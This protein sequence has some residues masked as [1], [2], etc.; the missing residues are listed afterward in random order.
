[1]KWCLWVFV[2]GQAF[3]SAVAIVGGLMGS[4]VAARTRGAFDVLFACIMLAIAYSA[5]A[6]L[7]AH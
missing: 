6:W 1:M 7:A 5:Y 3:E 2:W 4:K